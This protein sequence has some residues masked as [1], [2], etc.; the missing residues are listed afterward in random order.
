MMIKS[1]RVLML[2]CISNIALAQNKQISGVVFDAESQSPLSGVL[3]LQKN[4]QNGTYTNQ[5]GYFTLM[6]SDKAKD[7]EVKLLGYE[8]Q[9]IPINNQSEFKVVLKSSTK[10]LNDVV[11]TA[12]GL[13]RDQKDVG[14]A[15]QKLDGKEISQIKSPNF[16]DNL[17]GKVAG[18]T[19]QQGA[20]GVGSTSKIVIRSEASF[21]NNNPL[22]VV[23]GIP[24]N[25]NSITNFSNDDAAG[26]MA[27]DFG[28]G[29]MEINP[30]D[31]ASLTV[32]KGPSAAALYGTRASNGVIVISTKDGREK[33][34]VSVSFNSTSYL[35]R[36]FKLPE[37]QNTYGQGN[38]GKFEYKNGLGGGINDN[39]S[40][41]Y[42]PRMDAGL[43]IK[44]FDSP[45]Y[46]SD[47]RVVRGGDIA[48]YGGTDT[49]TP[50]A[51]IA[52]PDNLRDFYELGATQI[53][54]I[55]LS[56]NFDKGSYRVSFTDLRSD[57]YIPGVNLKRKTVATRLN[58]NPIE[59]L[60]TGININYMNSLSDNRPAGGYG[61]ENINYALVAWGPRNMNIEGMQDYWQ[62]GL[63]DTRQ[64]SFNY[65]FFD[66]PYF[67]LLE[68]KNA[69]NR[70]RVF[71]NAFAKYHLTN[72]LSVQVR[73]GM[74]F[75]N[76][77][78]TY[79]RAFSSNR[80]ASGAYAE[81]TV[82]YRENN[83]DVLLNYTK[84]VGNIGLDFY[85][86]ANRLDQNASNQQ[87][88]ANT[89]AQPGVFSLTNAASPLEIICRKAQKRI[90]SV[91]GVAKLSYKNYL[92]VDVT[93][94]ND[95]SSALA[96]INS[97]QNT[98]FFYPSVSGALIVS[99]L[100]A[101]PKQVSFVK[102]R[103]NYGQVGNDTD[104]YQTSGVYVAQ[105]PYN[106]SPTLTESGTVANTNLLP[107]K[108]SSY[109]LGADIRFF[110]DRVRLDATYY[111][112]NTSNQIIAL[113]IPISSGYSQQVV[114]GSV[115]NSEGVELM[116]GIT[117]VRNSRVT[118]NTFFNFS[119]NVS[120]VV[121]LPD[122]IKKITIDYNR[123][124]DNVNQTVWYQVEEGGRIG[125]IYGTGYKKTADGRFIVNSA[126]NL[127]ADNN[128]K[129]LGNYNPDFILT[130]N[131]Q[132]NIK[133][134][135][136][137][138]LVDWRQGGILVSRTLALA[139]VGGQLAE[140]E[141]RPDAG[142]IVDGVVN[143]GTEADPVYVE[144]TTA[145]T[146]ESYYRQYYDRNH[147]E[148]NT[149][150]ASYAKLRELS[151]GYT[152]NGKSE[153]G[154]LGNGRTLSVALVGRNL[155]A[156]SK[157]PHFDPEQ[158]AVQNG[159]FL[160]GVEDMSYPTARM[161]GFKLGYNF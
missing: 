63:E 9:L 120:T 134:F 93:G 127:I 94:R 69:F 18:V 109:E 111:T 148:N 77:L 15:L 161:F 115:I 28:N 26:L 29:G 152:F 102:L 114:N 84:K 19:I 99:N 149:Y 158:L 53:S 57:S 23:D 156:I 118:W 36:P 22:F 98:D 130:F 83:T 88:Q 48:L 59:K 42:G 70:D 74:D 91:Y 4:T 159:R 143:T 76:E 124:Y 90:N 131:N 20:T 54:N 21:A 2:L 147:E 71:G 125:D 6:L 14:Y 89:L 5:E 157:I 133:K 112:A 101:M 92:Y 96:T 144:N 113:P 30:D 3:I 61:S 128:L 87:M 47:G 34:G 139:A 110:D 126:G 33:K 86:G 37:F 117:P 35:E 119:R 137:G 49:I 25:N 151:L 116:L 67:T 65:T 138:F 38:S 135:N 55:A 150:D 106:S 123:V 75:S 44:Q 17:T 146:A 52:N 95:W 97:I 136:I 107:E 45:V 72:Q 24:I 121:D 80:F 8:S 27:V 58:F 79:K 41:S 16:L 39:I 103:A 141:D 64:Y 56:N 60:E 108:T 78:R 11:I 32:L 100:V 1:I 155:Y 85:A 154:F 132:L 46:T 105:T 40:Y 50:T 13:E 31:I 51:F 122:G 7:L 73:T 68:N 142:I 140:T 153:L 12:L 160:S 10:N 43:F 81:Q 145:I 82:Q 104:P 129:K 62:P 66:N